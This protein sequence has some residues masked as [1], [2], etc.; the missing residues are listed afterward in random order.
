MAHRR[1][2][3]T[4][5]RGAK[6][7]GSTNSWCATDTRFVLRVPCM[8]LCRVCAGDY[9]DPIIAGDASKG[10]LYHLQRIT[11]FDNVPANGTHVYVY[12]EADPPWA[13]GWY[14]GVVHDRT[15]ADISDDEAEP[16]P[17]GRKRKQ[18]TKPGKGR[19]RRRGSPEGV[20]VWGWSSTELRNRW[21]RDGAAE[22]ETD[23]LTAD[24]TATKVTCR[25]LIGRESH[26]VRPS[27]LIKCCWV[28]GIYWCEACDHERWANEN[29]D[30]LVPKCNCEGG[31]TG[32]P[33]ADGT[34][35]ATP[36]KRRT[37]P[38]RGRCK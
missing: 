14:R 37:Y 20:A 31:A 29:V 24:G 11:H 12:F 27:D 3:C 4:L 15:D 8:P 28:C 5:R 7:W 34:T 22:D 18:P 21:I 35:G 38:P 23:E 6:H 33:A 17:K 26:K 10:Y 13:G 30:K 2:P 25:G 1:K 9:S 19:S 36:G 16:E 32:K